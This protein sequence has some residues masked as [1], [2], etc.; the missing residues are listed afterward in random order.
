MGRSR[1]AGAPG[2]G[3]RLRRAVHARDRLAGRPRGPDGPRR[4]DRG[5]PARQWDPAGAV[6]DARSSWPPPRPPCRSARAAA[7]SWA[8]APGR[9]SPAPSSG[10]GRSW[11]WSGD[12]CRPGRPA[13]T[14]GSS[15]SVSLPETPPPIWLAA[16]GPKAVRMAGELADG[17][18]LNWC[19]PERVRQAREEVAEG[20]RAAGRDP[21]EVTVGVY[22]RACLDPDVMAAIDAVQAMVGAVRDLSGLRTTVRGDGVRRRHRTGGRRVPRRAAPGCPR[23]A[24][25]GRLPRRRLPPRHGRGSTTTVAPAPTSRWSIRSWS[26]AAARPTPRRRPWAGWRRRNLLQMPAQRVAF[27]RSTPWKR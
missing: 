7:C 17:V 21:A 10:S 4:R 26:P 12:S 16:L 27:E 14:A 23:A 8:S 3:R 11:A 18:L 19:T 24:G 20:A 13:W 25:P 1:G 2:R 15:G 5:P 22:V 9:R 6:A